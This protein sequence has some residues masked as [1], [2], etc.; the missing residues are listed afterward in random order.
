MYGSVKN[1]CKSFGDLKV[2]DNISIDFLENKVTC[3]LGPSG[4]GKTTLLNI[5]SSIIEP[6][7]GIVQGFQDKSISYVFQEDRLL[8]WRT[9]EENLTFVLKDKFSEKEIKGLVKK[10]LE[11]VGLYEYKNYYPTKLSGGMRQR[12]SIA[13]AF[14]YPSKILIMDEAFKSL[15]I[16]SKEGLMKYF[17][18]LIKI[19]KRTV[20]YVTH[21]IEEAAILGDTIIIITEKPAR[22]KKVLENNIPEEDRWGRKDSVD[23]FVEEIRKVFVE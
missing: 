21:D 1:I 14:A 19:D 22:V 4:C 11:M 7:S 16:A 18:E 6:D 8:E 10:Y 13:R 17:Y 9:V 3:I 12:V 23:I 2:L 5:L 15:D 20:I